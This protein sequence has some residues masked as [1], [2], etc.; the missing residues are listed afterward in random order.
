MQGGQQKVALRA[1]S[2]DPGVLVAAMSADASPPAN[3]F[4]PGDIIRNV[5]RATVRSVDELRRAVAGMQEGDPVAVQVERQG[6][7]TFV[8]FEID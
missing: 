4:Q 6:R 5:N 3:R 7:L 2:S 8:A 1:R